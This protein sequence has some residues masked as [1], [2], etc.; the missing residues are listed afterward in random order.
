MSAYGQ[1]YYHNYY[2]YHYSDY[3]RY[4]NYQPNDREYFRPQPHTPSYY[5]GQA[6]Y[7]TSFFAHP[8]FLSTNFNQYGIPGSALAPS[9]RCDNRYRAQ[10]TWP[11]LHQ[12]RHHQWGAQ[13]SAFP[14]TAYSR[15]YPSGY[16][17]GP[18]YQFEREVRYFPYPVY[19]NQ[20]VSSFSSG[21]S[22]RYPALS[23]F[24]YTTSNI[25][26]YANLNP[27]P[28]KIRV[29]FIPPSASL[30]QQQQQLCN[31]T[32]VRPFIPSLAVAHTLWF[33]LLVHT[34]ILVQSDISTSMFAPF[35]T[36]ITTTII[37]T[38]T[39][40]CST[41]GYAAVFKSSSSSSVK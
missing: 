6:A 28:P 15:P 9:Y 8:G 32:P 3:N 4:Q 14:L 31:L 36:T 17:S 38:I 23:R 25:S 24:P 11:Y 41:N 18:V 35:A 2:P 20:G 34:T 37:L 29:I 10:D 16:N 40:C 39:T 33:T 5:S 1:H 12:R 7:Q 22:R 13:D 30:P 21:R 26:N 19:I 27:L